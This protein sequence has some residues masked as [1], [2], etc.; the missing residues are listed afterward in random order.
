MDEWSNK[1]FPLGCRNCGQ[2]ENKHVGHGL[3]QR[4]YR[5]PEVLQSAKDGTLET[6][7]YETLRIDA[8][9]L[10]DIDTDDL[11]IDSD[12][13][14]EVRPGAVSSP[15][16]DWDELPATFDD[17]PVEKIKSK[18]FGKKKP[19]GAPA[20]VTKEKAPK[21][22]GRRQ[23]TA[24]TIEDFWSMLGGVAIRSGLHAPLGRYMM[25][26]AP[27]A[28]EMVDQ[29]LAGSFLDKKILQPT[30]KARGRLDIVGALL[31]PPAIILAIE[32]NPAR[33]MQLM[34][35]L[36]SSIRSSL[37]TILPAMKKAAAREE[38]VNKAITEMFG[39]DFP[40]G[41]DPVDY[42]IESMFSGFFDMV[43][44]PVNEDESATANAGS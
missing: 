3:C 22:S 7:D 25:W 40:A 26:Q 2:T 15:A 21:G 39:D 5:I 9:F 8:E 35:V 34:P 13:W 16:T 33:A 29:A 31:G 32:M 30:V 20:P 18:I 28:G 1:K 12:G 42:V 44:T 6:V 27:A 37:P 36:K 41:V 43:P 10:D 14:P 17:S 23:S 24:E 11:V 38:K 19:A 4:C